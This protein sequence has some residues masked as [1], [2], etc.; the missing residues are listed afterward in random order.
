MERLKRRIDK[1]A[2][3]VL[4]KPKSAVPRLRFILE[5]IITDNPNDLPGG[6]GGR[7]EKRVAFD[8]EGDDPVMIMPRPMGS[9][10]GTFVPSDGGQ[11]QADAL[12]VRIKEL[13]ERR[14]RLMEKG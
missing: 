8:F 11:G 10:V 14:R 12:R 2:E 1:A 13:E 3:A 7:D 4:P 6:L 5:R 9:T